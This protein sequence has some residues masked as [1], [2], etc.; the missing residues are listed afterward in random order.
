MKFY[1]IN[2]I[3]LLSGLYVECGAWTHN[4]DTEILMLYW[5]SQPGSHE[6]LLYIFISVHLLW[7][8]FCLPQIQMLKLQLSNVAICGDEAFG[9]WLGHDDGV[10]IDGIGVLTKEAPES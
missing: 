5:L 6:I 1:F 9:G 3:Y 8:D 2:L 4:T 10:L 7:A